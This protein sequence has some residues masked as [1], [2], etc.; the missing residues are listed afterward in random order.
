MID[1]R[2]ISIITIFCASLVGSV[3]PYFIN[4]YFTPFIKM[5]SAGI[6]LSLS[7]V[8][9]VPD[10]INDLNIIDYPLG[11][12][13]ILLGI[14]FLVIVENLSH[15]ILTKDK[16]NNL[17]EHNS[18][19][20]CDVDHH[21]NQI[22]H[23]RSEHNHTC[24]NNLNPSFASNLVSNFDYEV[25]PEGYTHMHDNKDTSIIILYIFEF[26]CVF[27]SFIIGL[28]LG[29][30][31]DQDN[32]KKLMIAL[33]FHQMVEGLSLG[34]MILSSNAEKIKSC[35]FIASYS[36]MTPLGISIGLIIEKTSVSQSHDTGNLDQDLNKNWVITRG[37]FLGISAGMLIYISLIQIIME[38]LSKEKLH[39]KSAL[40]QKTYMYISMLFG[41]SIMCIIALW[42]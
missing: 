11:G 28:S 34:S 8:H 27:H 4:G 35:I 17:I 39:V 32:I 42:I 12:T 25:K 2:Y 15:S 9:I 31:T 33:L 22:E 29:L 16:D 41:A 5:F 3:L 14:M 10:S 24:I 38:E 13:M 37:C 36:L 23:K 30:I 6:I 21:N 1:F 18:S 7:L 26:A 19:N 20:N 40:Q